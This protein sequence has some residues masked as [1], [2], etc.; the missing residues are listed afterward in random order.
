VPSSA[1]WHTRGVNRAVIALAGA[2]GLGAALPSGAAAYDEQ[3]SLDV[4]AGWGLA[5]ALEMAPN[6][7]PTGALATTIGFDDAW[8]MG[9]NLGWAVHPAFTD[10]SDPFHVGI[11]GVEG[12][13]YI[14]ILE[15]V[16]FFGIGVDLLPTFDGTQWFVDFAAHLRL[17]LDYLVSREIAIGVDVRPYILLTALSTDPVYLTFQARVSF[18]FD[19]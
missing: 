2:L 10:D 19:Y 7:G 4:N 6:H 15:I 14:D 16:P 5:P 9:I 13:Y 18:L 12:L 11:A 8:A 17:S 1:A 3:V